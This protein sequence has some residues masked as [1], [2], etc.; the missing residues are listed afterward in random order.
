LNHKI[1]RRDIQ[2]T[3]S[4]IGG[5]KNGWVV[6]VDEAVEVLLADI[7]LVFAVQWNQQE[8]V[9]EQQWEDCGQIIDTRTGRDEENRFQGS[10]L[11]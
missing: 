4:D 5:E 2:S 1:D 11:N 10:G 6:R 7:C 8:I 9:T 3:R